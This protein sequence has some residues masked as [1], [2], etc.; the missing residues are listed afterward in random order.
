MTM[1]GAMRRLLQE[2]LR[3]KIK[4]RRAKQLNAISLRGSSVLGN[5]QKASKVGGVVGAGVGLLALAL[6]VGS[7]GTLTPLSM[8]LAAGAGSG[9]GALG[10]SKIFKQKVSQ[11]GLGSVPALTNID[12]QTKID[13]KVISDSIKRAIQTG[14]LVYSGGKLI[15]GA[16]GLMQAL[17]GTPTAP[18]VSMTGG[19][20]TGVTT[21]STTTAVPTIPAGSPTGAA[22]PGGAGAAN[23]TSQPGLLGRLGNLSKRNLNWQQWRKAKSSGYTGSFNDYLRTLK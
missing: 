3:Q 8:A 2:E 5:N 15:Q 13:K 10:A 4:N 17:K 9:V 22:F 19:T 1:T 16:G 7:G 14:A 18:N 11:V 20:A 12:M 23:A 21:P 6:A